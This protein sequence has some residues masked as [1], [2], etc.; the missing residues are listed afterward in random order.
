MSCAVHLTTGQKGD[1][2]QAAALIEG[3]PAE[4]VMARTAAYHLRQAIAAK[5]ALA[6]IPNNLSRAIKYPLGKHLY[7]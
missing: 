4:V 5:E 1:E 3:L 6:V 2:P 7:S